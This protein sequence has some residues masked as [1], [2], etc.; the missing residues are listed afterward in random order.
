MHGVLFEVIE[1][2]DACGEAG[3][4]HNEHDGRALAVSNP[5]QLIAESPCPPAE[6]ALAEA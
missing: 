2:L 5:E 6:A 4:S 1:A 3:R